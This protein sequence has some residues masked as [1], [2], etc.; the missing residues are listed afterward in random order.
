MDEQ[1][2][3][4]ALGLK[5]W[6]GQGDPAQGERSASGGPAEAVLDVNER[7]RLMRDGV[8][9]N[10]SLFISGLIG[11]VLVPIMLKGLG[12]ESYGLWIAALS[13]AGLVGFFDFGLGLSVTR[14]VAA[15]LSGKTPNEPTT[16]MRAAG[17]GYLAVGLTGA[18]LIATLGI[19]LS[20]G[21]RLSAAT[22]KIAPTV[23]ALAGVAFLADRLL[24]FT[25]A[26]LRGLRR[27]DAA[28]LLSSL[29]A[30]FRAFGII[31]LIKLGTGLLTVMT[32]QVVAAVAVALAGQAVVGRL[33]PE[34]RFKVGRLDWKLVRSH[35]PFGL[36][37]QLTSMMEVTIWDMAPV[38]VGLILGSRWIAPFYIAQKFPTAAAL[39]IWSAAEA[40]FPAASQHRKDEGIAPTREILEV[41]TRWTV[42]LALPLCLG[43][44]TLAPRLLE[45]WIGNVQPGSALILRLIAAA[46]FM[47]GVAAGPIQVLWG[48]GEMRILLIVP[49]CVMVT[50]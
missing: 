45:A 44:W 41:G 24:A 46:V 15:S 16:F 17:T 3:D 36:A 26:V 30:L 25:M 47:E 38:V 1:P 33:K 12:A 9:N 27:F 42:A 43:L 34:F 7:V 21:L 29:A 23:F 50:S 18:V 31:A 19:P 20:G 40:L 28:N 13:V 37:S 14:T 35:L 32:W 6:A 11:I 2:K 39:I 8:F 4:F 49:S 10:S 5:G 22:G 48:R